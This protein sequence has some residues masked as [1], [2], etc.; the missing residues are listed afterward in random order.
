MHSVPLFSMG[1]FVDNYSVITSIYRVFSSLFLMLSTSCVQVVY[2]LRSMGVQVS[3][4]THSDFIEAEG[5][6]ETGLISHTISTEIPH[7]NPQ[8]IAHT[9]RGNTLLIPSIH[10]TYKVLIHEK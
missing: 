3:V 2:A 6:V 1:Y 9:T 4:L 10:T 8:L 7:A 5:C